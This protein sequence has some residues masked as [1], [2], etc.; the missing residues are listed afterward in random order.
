MFFR[1]D[2]V[3]F[4]DSCRTAGQKNKDQL[5]KEILGKAEKHT[6]PDTYKKKNA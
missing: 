4:D 5:L 2:F 1:V 3:Y 6:Q